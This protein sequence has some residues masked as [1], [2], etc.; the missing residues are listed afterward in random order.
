M[1]DW[2]VIGGRWPITFLVK[3]TCSECCI[4]DRC[5]GDTDTE[6]PAPEGYM[7]VSAARKKDIEWEA[8]KDWKV[9]KVRKHYYD[10]VDMYVTGAIQPPN[11]LKE[12]NGC[13]YSCGTLIYRIGESEE[14]FFNRVRADDTRRFPVAFCDLVSENGWIAE[15][16]AYI[17]PGE[18]E[19]TV[20]DWGETIQQYIEDLDEEDVLVSVDYH[21]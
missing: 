4:G 2:Y 20:A 10:L 3:D 13:V 9:E 6:Y 21:M 12:E 19:V 11:Y 17:R 7:W 15:G 1:W 14:D 18:T 8:M 5:W 16:E